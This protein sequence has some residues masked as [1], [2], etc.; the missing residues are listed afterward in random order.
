MDK[1][2]NMFIT[3]HADNDLFAGLE[4]AKLKIAIG[5]SIM[6]ACIQKKHPLVNIFNEVGIPIP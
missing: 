5:G 4:W 3:R 1:N 2:I 6:S